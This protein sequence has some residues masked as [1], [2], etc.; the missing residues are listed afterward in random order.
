MK[1]FRI[2]IAAA[3]TACIMAAGSGIVSLAA[4][5]EIEAPPILY[6]VSAAS[7]GE[8]YLPLTDVM[9]SEQEEEPA[10][11]DIE[12]I[13]SENG[14]SRGTEETDDDK[15]EETDGDKTEETDD[16][17]T[18]ETDDDKTE[19]NDDG[20]TEETDDD[21]TEETDDGRTEET[22]DGET[23]ETD[24]GKTEETDGGKT[25]ETGKEKN[26][27]TGEGKSGKKDKGKNKGS[28]ESNADGTGAEESGE[29]VSTPT[30][31]ME[32]ATVDSP[33]YSK[34]DTVEKDGAAQ[35]Q[36]GKVLIVSIPS[37]GSYDGFEE[38]RFTVKLH[39]EEKD[40]K[41]ASVYPEELSPVDTDQGKY[42]ILKYNLGS[43]QFE[44][45]TAEGYKA[46]ETIDLKTEP[47]IVTEKKFP[48]LIVITAVVF[49]AAAIG[50]AV[51]YFLVVRNRNKRVADVEKI[52]LSPCSELRVIKEAEGDFT[53]YCFEIK[54][55]SR[56]NLADMESKV[57]GGEVPDFRPSDLADATVEASGTNLTVTR[58][59]K[60]QEETLFTLSKTHFLAEFQSVDGTRWTFIWVPG[61]GVDQ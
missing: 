45:F 25:D 47:G 60:G 42:Y 32:T 44:A 31:S 11:K 54:D 28:D 30:L 3:V 52:K 2:R 40:L 23:E 51:S 12:A 8:E 21:K 16:D 36:K 49:L 24:G 46:G 59:A 29:D 19:E 18:E 17:K 13:K 37:N 38:I 55:R 53:C 57:D 33:G 22:E 34:A 50:G 41:S 4:A 5:G 1:H 58:S 9:K 14:D 27:G 15:T 61:I 35:G 7:Q 10:Q 26:N 39:S 20:R 56:T 43:G 6:T 48:W